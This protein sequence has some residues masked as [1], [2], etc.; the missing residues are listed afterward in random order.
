MGERL[1]TQVSGIESRI[2][3]HKYGQ[4]IF[5]KVTKVIHCRKEGIL[6]GIGTG[7]IRRP[8]APPPGKI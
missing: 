8:H 2:D 4:L 7:I 3:P 1:H 5:N 6:N